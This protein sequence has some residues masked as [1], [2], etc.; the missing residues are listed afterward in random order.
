M[1]MS[2]GERYTVEYQIRAGTWCGCCSDFL[3]FLGGT[4]LLLRSSACV[5]VCVRAYEQYIFIFNSLSV[6]HSQ[7]Q[8]LPHGG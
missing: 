2:E 6:G 7:G 8:G 3:E 4:E 5:C 1:L